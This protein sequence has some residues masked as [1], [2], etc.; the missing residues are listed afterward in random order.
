MRTIS[1]PQP[2]RVRI[3]AL[4]AV[5]VLFVLFLS[6]N[7]VASFYTDWLWFDNMD[8]GSIW[9]TILGT[10]VLLAVVFTAVF[11]LILW[12]NLTLADRLKPATRPESPE[13]DLVERYHAVVG[14]QAGKVRFGVAALFGLIAGANTS[15]QWQ[16]WL[17]FRSGGEFGVNDAQF[18][19][20]VGFYVFRLPFWT[21][22]VDWFFAALVLTLIVVVVAH[23]L[24]GGIRASVPQEQRVTAGVKFHISVLLAVL[25]LLRAA[26]Y[27]LDR[28]HLVT[29]TRGAYD[30]ALATDVNIQLPA[31][32]LLTLISLFCAALF[33]A[34]IRRPGWGLPVVAIGIWLVSHFV[35]GGL[36][37][38]VYQRVRV[39]PVQ[40][41]REAMFVERNIEAT[42]FAYGLDPTNV[43]FDYEPELTPADLDAYDDVVTNVPV[44]DPRLA[45]EEVTR[46]EAQRSI[47]SF[48]DVLDVDRYM[49]G[50]QLRPVVL[51]ARELNVGEVGE[52]WERQHVIFTHGHG[53]AMA[54][55]Y[56]ETA[57][58]SGESRNLDYLIRGLGESQID[59]EL[60]VGFEQPR[61][62]FGEDLDGYA[63]VGAA[64]EEVDFQ[65]SGNDS[66]LYRYTGEGGVPMGSFLRRTAFAL[67]FRELDPLIS[68]NVTDDSKVIYNREIRER[69]ENL[70]PFLRFDS[71]PYPVATDDGLFWIVD[72]YTTTADFPYSQSVQTSVGGELSSGYNYVRNS[73]KVVID[74]Y[75]GTVSMYVID[76]DDP[77][78]AAW[79]EVFPDLFIDGDE[80]PADIRAHLK[81]PEDIFTVQTD[82]WANYVVD[83]ATEFIQ[84]DVAWSVAAQPRTEAQAVEETTGPSGSMK[85]QYLMARLPGSDEAEFVLQRIFVPRSGAAGS[86]TA[87]PKITGIMMARSD[88]GN[89]GELVLVN[90]PGGEADAPDLVHSDIRKNDEL[91]V[92]IREKAGAEVEFGD[93]SVLLLED[94]IVYIRPVY[95]ESNSATAVPELQR[96]VAVNGNRIFMGGSVAEAVRGVVSGGS[97]ATLVPDADVD[98]GESTGEDA[99]PPVDV[100][101]P[102]GKSV[103]ELIA[104]AEALLSDAAGA[105]AQGLAE[106]AERMREGARTALEAARELLGGQPTTTTTTI[107]PVEEPADE[108]AVE[109]GEEEPESAAGDG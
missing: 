70:A 32:N 66:V 39:D 2:S 71:D 52:T 5:A 89:Y 44:V 54:A 43:D 58:V 34:N 79:S 8:L 46:S 22:L 28:Y 51:S 77:I 38:L 4:V 12:G 84:G 100:Y 23:Y 40:S 102:T 50:G 105:E 19:R 6:A 13:E 103:V 72:G 104:D 20:D 81:Y 65:T 1:P 21:F 18:D 42:R 3:F 26:A 69:V 92:F 87:R 17:L 57:T 31:L 91:T 63:I 37:P 11:F 62:Y 83:D 106:E 73:V 101:D 36:F 9:T 88:P 96:V 61:I 24:N 55:A 47:Y 107:P 82:M 109:D 99:A 7:G 68:R 53:L 48:S 86:S 30:G 33:V 16:T 85:P 10:R 41:Q 27:W 49:I 75:N 59:G 98:P 90:L 35:I 74:A 64:R 95:V 97:A 93:M 60:G 76:Q 14:A 94:T 67:R 108:A 56:D 45:V 78:I 15:S 29:S 25:A 80:M